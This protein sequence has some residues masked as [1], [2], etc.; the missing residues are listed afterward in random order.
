MSQK[1]TESNI[2][3]LTLSL[4]MNLIIPRSTIKGRNAIL[5]KNMDKV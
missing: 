3:N 1:H 2:K 4:A 5:I